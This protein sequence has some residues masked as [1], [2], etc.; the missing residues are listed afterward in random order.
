[1]AL[2]RFIHLGDLHLGP[3]ARNADRYRALEQAIAASIKEPIAA[4]LWPGDLNHG[5]MTIEDRNKLAAVLTVMGAYAPVVL[6]YGN[7]DLPGDLDVFAKL[8]TDWPIAVVSR[9]EVIDFLTPTGEHVALFVLP[10]PTRAGLVA[11]G[12]PSDGVVDAARQALD[13]IFMGAAVQLEQFRADGSI[14]LMIGHVNVAGAITSSG[15]PNIGKEIELDELLLDRL[16]RIYKG[17]NH[18]HRR[19]QYYAGSLCRLDWGEVEPKSFVEVT[20]CD[21]GGRGWNGHNGDGPEDGYPDGWVFDARWVPLDVAPMYHVDG[22]LTRD[23]FKW[24]ITK[25]EDGGECQPPEGGWSGCEVRV[26]YRFSAHEKSALDEALVRAPFEGAKRID[27]DP[28]AVR[29][30]AVRAP[31]VAAAQTLDAKVAAFVRSSGQAWTPEMESKLAALQQPDGA[32]FL[33]AVQQNLS[34][35]Q[36]PVSPR[37]SGVVADPPVGADRTLA[38]VMR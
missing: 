37:S 9:P 8:K 1:M 28:I 24:W 11:A 38:E 5:R 34:A 6:C 13:V 35:P 36:T 32:A 27:L 31:E 21:N 10:Y 23:G 18:I 20:Y 2:H 19:Q 29:D 7:H 16:G 12:V 22:E 4:W 33:T 3:N 14:T 30:R 26:R 17:L 15:Q 25:S